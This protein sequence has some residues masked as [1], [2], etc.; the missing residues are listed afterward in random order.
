MRRGRFSLSDLPAWC[1]LNN[2][3]FVDVKATDINDRGYGLIADT[4]LID[5]DGDADIPALLT[6]PRDLVLSA[7]GVEEY[8]KENK[9]FRQ[10]LD[11]VGRRSTRGDI[12]LFLL[13]QLVLS[14]PDYKGGQGPSTPWTQYFSL[15]PS[16]VS[17]PTMWS[18]SEL[19]YLKGTSLEP[20]VS[21]KLTA[22]TKEFDDIRAKTASLPFWD[23]TFSIDE[24]VTIQ[25]WILLDALYRSRSLGLPHS[26]EAMVPCLDLVNHSSKA[27]AYFDENGDG[28]IILRLRQGCGVSAGNEITIDYGGDKSPAEMLFS[29]GFIDTDST[30]TSLTLPLEPFSDDP[31]ATAKLHAFGTPPKLKLAED[32]TGNPHWTAPFVYLMCLNEEDGLQFRVLQET[33]GSRHLKMFWQDTDVTHE[34]DAIVDHIH[35]HELYPL[36]KLRV[37]TVLYDIFQTKIEELTGTR[38]RDM[39]SGSTR[40]EIWEVVS[41]L[42]SLEAGIIKKCLRVLDEEQTRLIGDD[43]VLEYLNSTTSD[44]NDTAA[45]AADDEEDFS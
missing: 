35:N 32:D 37:I 40:E 6:I 15:L 20:A 43:K 4:D 3:T 28:E 33:D 16:H 13:V 17:T 45:G 36:F 7:E 21:A 14:S 26:G 42:N 30:V 8:A 12:L 11:I 25:D 39:I 29:Y 22:L 24:S 10:L 31:L 1:V 38:D 44:R 19:S 23:E 9:D 41:R 34:P 5:E 18:E 27:N 2:V